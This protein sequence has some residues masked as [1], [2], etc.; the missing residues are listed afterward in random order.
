MRHRNDRA[1]RSPSLFAIA[2]VVVAVGLA[3]LGTLVMFA[4]VCAIGSGDD[5]VWGDHCDTPLPL[6]TGVVGI[7]LA[8]VGGAAARRSGKAWP[9]AAGAVASAAIALWPWVLLGD[10]AGNF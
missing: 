10:P 5:R 2:I 9:L 7:S 3:N 6:M 1:R 8:L 4:L